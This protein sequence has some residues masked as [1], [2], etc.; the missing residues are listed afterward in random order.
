M[1]FQSLLH[2][3]QYPPPDSIQFIAL[4]CEIVLWT[5]LLLKKIS[6]LLGF[7][8]LVLRYDFPYIPL[9][10]ECTD[11]KLF[12]LF[13]LL[14]SVCVVGALCS[15]RQYLSVS[16]LCDVTPLASELASWEPSAGI[17]SMLPC[18][19][20]ICSLSF[21]CNLSQF[22]L[23]IDSFQSFLKSIIIFFGGISYL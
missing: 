10:E 23:L 14:M 9:F 2:I 22:I 19:T 5:I 21:C 17:T 11:V 15:F 12:L 1:S 20:D 3:S 16:E 4:H 7:Y 8:F 13:C 6:K 18:Q